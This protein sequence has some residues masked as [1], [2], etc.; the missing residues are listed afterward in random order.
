VLGL[1]DIFLC[2]PGLGCVYQPCDCTG[3]GAAFV[4]AVSVTVYYYDVSATS[5]PVDWTVGISQ[6]DSNLRIAPTAD[7]SSPTI[8]ATPLGNVGIA[9]EPG[10]DSTPFGPNYYRLDVDGRIRCTNVTQTS[11]SRFK[12]NIRPIEAALDK[13]S[14]LRGVSFDWDE[15]H[16]GRHEL[17]FV[18]EEVGKVA[19]E[20]VTWEPDGVNAAGMQYDRVSALTVEA[21]KEQQRQIDALKSENAALKARLD[22]LE[23]VL[24]KP[25]TPPDP[26]EAPD[27]RE[28][29]PRNRRSCGPRRCASGD[30]Y[31]VA[32]AFTVSP[33]N[34]REKNFALRP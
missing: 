8:I 32:A 20:L 22:A 33:R 27:R 29:A 10:F 9:R 5:T 14:R 18:A 24:P 4:D 2:L 23:A 15:A 3:S 12:S 34:D 13:V 16:G 17:G 7:L 30:R 21:V 31:A 25:P 28:L 11:S 19:P 6:D 1:S 26:V